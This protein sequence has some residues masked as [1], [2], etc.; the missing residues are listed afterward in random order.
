MKEIDAV[1][2]EAKCLALLEEVKQTGESIIILE[3]G[4]PIAELSPA[5]LSEGEHPLHALQGSVEIIE[6]ITG[7]LFTNDGMS[8][9]RA[10]APEEALKALRGSVIRYDDPLE[11]VIKFP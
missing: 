4:K 10:A 6:D 2:F 5:R 8:V 7:P 11:P 9:L 3:H 1:E